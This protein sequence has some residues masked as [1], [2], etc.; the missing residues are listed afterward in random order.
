MITK[1][2]LMRIDLNEIINETDFHELKSEIPYLNIVDWESYKEQF[3]KQEFNK[4]M[5]LIL[6][7]EQA[8]HTTKAIRNTGKVLNTNIVEAN[9]ISNKLKV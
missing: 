4:N 7:S 9:K 2:L 3:T 1:D 5:Q 6:F 8:L